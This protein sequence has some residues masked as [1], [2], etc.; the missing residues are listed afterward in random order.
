MEIYC[1]K[2]KEWVMK[3]VNYE[4]KDMIALTRDEKEYHDKHNKCFTCNERF[5]YD[6][7]N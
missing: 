5:C 6:K 3:I 7:K 4:M 2:L 1:K